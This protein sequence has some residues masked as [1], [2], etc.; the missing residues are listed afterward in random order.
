MSGAPASV[1]CAAREENGDNCKAGIGAGSDWAL[2]DRMAG[3]WTTVGRRHYCPAH[4]TEA[5]ERAEFDARAD[6]RLDAVMAR[7][8]KGALR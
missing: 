3:R 7:I 6:R 8:R 2:R 4:K 1:R 5:E